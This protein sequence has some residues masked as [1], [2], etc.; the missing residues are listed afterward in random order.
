MKRQR[1]TRRGFTSSV[2]IRLMSP[3]ADSL[4]LSLGNV[5]PRSDVISPAEKS[6]T[7]AKE[8]L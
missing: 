8:H 4:P 7:L 6:P 2:G 5:G 3:R 1:R